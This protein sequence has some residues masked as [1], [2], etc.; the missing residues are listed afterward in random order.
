MASRSWAH[1]RPRQ[2]TTSIFRS[3]VMSL[4]QLYIPSDVARYTVSQLGEL[5]LVQFRDL[6][7]EVTAFQRSFV[8]DVRRFDE[9]ERKL[10]YLRAQIDLS[11]VEVY[12]FFDS[13]FVSTARGPRDIDDMEE[14]I[15]AHEGRVQRLAAAYKEMH[16]NHIELI[17][18]M[19]VLQEVSSLFTE[20]T[21]RQSQAHPRSG[22][23][24]AASP[25]AVP[26]LARS[27]TA[28]SRR[29]IGSMDAAGAF[30]VEL[31]AS[32]AAAA[33]ATGRDIN[34]GFISGVIARDRIATLER[35]LWR[36]L[37]GN[38]FL[39][40]VDIEAPIQDNTAE[41]GAAPVYK[42]AFIVFA[43]GDSLRDRATKIAES[44]G[45][46][47]YRVDP[48]AERRQEDLIDTMSR[49]DDL[50][51]ILDNNAV[52]RANELAAVAE[53]ITTWLAVVRKEKATY[54]ALNLFNHDAN[55][56]CLIA[57]GWCAANDI[58]AIQSAL[59]LAT[60][61]AGSTVPTVLHELR[62]TK[63]PPTFV[64]TNRFTE[65]FQNIVD[66]YGVPKAGEVNPGLFT[67]ITF[68]FL[69]ALMFGDLGHGFLMTLCAALLCIYEKKLA[70]MAKD[71]S[72][73]MFYSG[74]YIVLLMGIFSMFTGFIYNDIFSRAMSVFASGWA[75][76]T[77]HGGEGVIVEATKLAHTYAVGI[78][79]AW[80]HASNSLLF[81]NSYKMK[82]SIV[83]GVIHMTLGICLQVPNA[84]HFK[85]RIN[86]IH[87]FVPQLIFLFSIFGYLVFTIIFKWS[88]DWYARDAAGQLTH[89]SPP[90]LLNM[91]IY[92]F[93][94]PGSVNESER[95]FRGQAF[96][97][98]FLLL[99]ALVCVPWMLL[100]KPLI[101]RREH[102][103]ITSEGYGRIS[104]H[105]RVSTEADGMAGAIIVA[106]QEEM[107]ADD[108]DFADIMINQ[109][110]HTIEF[111]LNSISNTASYLRL[112]ALS[113]AHAQLSEVLWSM[114]FLPTLKITGSYKPFAIMFGFAVWFV[115][116]FGI[117]IGME[118][119]SA[120]LHAL[121]L[122]WVE[123]NNKFYDGTGVKFEP[124]SFKAVLDEADD[125]Q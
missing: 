79:P 102:R 87:V 84:L 70:W 83:L 58:P 59:H 111:C 67:I 114:I 85:K 119:L 41:D 47:L 124:F 100:V 46:T 37:R 69:F 76:P 93:L 53:H 31:G 123:F 43:H 33:A 109:S 81:T 77:T 60:E 78:D 52:A 71:E 91:L 75:W 14:R 51:L 10:R 29:S 23:I 7:A 39:N 9:I 19:H 25:D 1:A 62:T 118:G 80:H 4:V 94:S 73:R 57:E 24:A 11:G 8:N 104:S 120:F 49:L 99:T 42:S 28:A 106:E 50:R 115:L 35:V 55:R 21:G 92:M 45:A 96:L 17:E 66:A 6:N 74:R 34:I 5:G 16:A 26:L 89:I 108:F 30:D 101:M 12:D 15:A 121:R 95:M 68:P 107:Q 38:M 64:R 110:I 65:G 3:E 88:T 56:N 54:H 27:D 2:K 105:V 36:S 82:M 103:K 98:T 117:L 90:S 72:M 63:Q 13:R 48:R 86:I 40:Y 44:L 61:D 125:Q 116:T 97:Q 20:I 122:H 18:N 32:A 113:L 22:S 112:W